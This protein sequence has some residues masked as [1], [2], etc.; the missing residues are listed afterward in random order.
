MKVK[1]IL[2]LGLKRKVTAISKTDGRTVWC[3]DLRGGGFGSSSGFITLVCDDEL[4]FAYYGGHLH[5]LELATG[6]LLW[7]NELPGYGFGLASLCV[8]GYGFSPDSTTIRELMSQ[9]ESSDS[10]SAT[11][12]TG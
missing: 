1:E 4:V 8:P 12:A 2:L 5:C 10:G 6:K 3:T 7:T 11:A 9:Q